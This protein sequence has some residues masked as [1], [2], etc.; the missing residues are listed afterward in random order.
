MKWCCANRP[1][2]VSALSALSAASMLVVDLTSE[3]ADPRAVRMARDS[4]LCVPTLDACAPDA[5]AAREALERIDAS[6]KPV[7]IHCAQGHGRTGSFA[8]ALLIRRGL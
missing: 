5:T 8:A 7:Y 6:D 1:G 3:F 2:A 4:Y